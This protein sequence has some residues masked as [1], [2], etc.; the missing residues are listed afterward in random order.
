MRKLA[1]K[2]TSRLVTDIELPDWTFVVSAAG[3]VIETVSGR[4]AAAK[5]QGEERDGGKLTDGLPDDVATLIRM[6]ISKALRARSDVTFAFDL[7]G[8]GETRAYEL[9]L[10]VMG[11]KRLLGM[12]RD[13]ERFPSTRTAASAASG[14]TSARL[15]AGEVLL[16]GALNDAR[17]RERG[18]AA[19]VIGFDQLVGATK[20]FGKPVRRA[21]L[22]IAAR[23]I[24]D[25]LR[26]RDRDSEAGAEIA[27]LN[28]D[29]FL[30]VLGGVDGREAA[31]RVADR[32]RRAFMNPLS[33]DGY[34]L[35]GRP[36]IGIAL[37]PSDGETSEELLKHARVALD[38]AAIKG[39]DGFA[40]YSNTMRFRAAQRL[41]GKAE[42]KWALENN[43]L[44]LRY[45]PRVDLETGCVA[46][47]EALLRWEHPL[48]GIVALDEVL[49]LAEATGLMRPLG[50]WV[51]EAAC[52]QAA[53]WRREIE[54]LP[55][56]S[57]NLSEAE[58]TRDG[59]GA[60]VL[61]AL[62]ASGLPPESLELE[63]QEATLMRTANAHGILRDL[64]QIGV[65]LV[66]DD[67]GVGYSSLARLTE[68]PVKAIKIDR[69]FVDRSEQG[70]SERS[71]CSAIIA[72]ATSLGL[73]VIAE[74]VENA[75]QID[76][77]R[78]QGCHAL[79]GFFFTEPLT[80]DLVPGFLDQHLQAVPDGTIVD[81]DTIRTRFRLY[82]AI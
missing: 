46:G 37:H 75:E 60:L 38:E 42:L 7:H 23:R 21:M 36:A 70:D 62:E 1:E 78:E 79:Q 45:L 61:N 27:R 25:C 56:V 12:L 74:G 18:L 40:F 41:D 55:P 8:S 66:V 43:Q 26:R 71:V 5:F 35:E 57:I 16:D 82:G 3:D 13:L 33:H 80:A 39:D 14:S 63:I 48:R 77:L 67:F 30:V 54:D 20:R 51:L 15:P 31:S 47:L 24:E 50:E 44:G 52:A 65:G 76:F 53:H 2:L 28:R 29:E 58:F 6:N 73:T 4:A 17:I 10:V 81:L 34:E 9:R 72:L 49:P 22:S 59:L 64:E 19:L 32:I 69:S 68:L 11:R